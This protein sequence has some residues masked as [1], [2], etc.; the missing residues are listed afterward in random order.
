MENQYWYLL[1]AKSIVIYN[2]IRPDRP[3]REPSRSPTTF[4]F[5][6]EKLRL[7]TQESHDKHVGV[8]V[9]WINLATYNKLFRA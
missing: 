9:S 6:E 1:C 3:H 7:Q 8:T 5:L 4:V 2:N